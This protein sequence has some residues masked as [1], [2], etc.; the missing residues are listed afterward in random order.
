MFFHAWD[1]AEEGTE[2]VIEWTREAGLN[3]ICL[4][5]TYHHGWFLH[6]HGKRHRAFRSEGDVCYFQPDRSCYQKTVLFPQVAQ[7]ATR[8]DWLREIENRLGGDIRLVAWTIGAHHTGF[9]L[10]YPE[11]TVQ[12]VYGDRL[13]HALCPANG[14]VAAYLKALC[15]DLASN[16][17][18]WGLQLEAFGWMPFAHGHHHERD[19]VGL[20][21]LEQELMGLCVCPS[22]STRA[23][24]AG[25]E[26]AEVVA[27]VKSVLDAAF[28]ES[29]HR[30]VNHP[31]TMEELQA[32][33]RTVKDFYHWRRN[34][35]NSL[36]KEIKSE[37]LKG[38]D[39]R[40]LL[41]TE[42][43]ADLSKTV[44]GFACASYQRT[45]KQTREICKA[46]TDGPAKNFKG[47]MQCLVQ[48]GMGTPGSEDELREIISAVAQDRCNGINFYDYSEAPPKMLSWLARTLP[49]FSE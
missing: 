25:V 40:I 4:A 49:A 48:L 47:L 9:G 1:F 23:R 15:R 14:A 39:C 30:S 19:L 16:H 35:L 46:A 41:Q 24:E 27:V 31:D 21:A 44:D 7:I 8:K 11:C 22:C 33:Y 26:V 43:D 10:A 13:P 42:F 38:T 45:A 2:N 6:P 37:S 34:Y 28:R 32:N 12:N 18:L 20:T 29:P 5:A 3:V 17:S 36:I